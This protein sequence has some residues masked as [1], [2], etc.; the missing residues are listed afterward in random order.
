MSLIATI[1][2][3]LPTIHTRVRETGQGGAG[4]S[5]AVHP[6]PGKDHTRARRAGTFIGHLSDLRVSRSIRI[7]SHCLIAGGVSIADYDGHPLD[8]AQRRGEATLPAA[9][10][11]SVKI[12]DDVWIGQGA[13]ILKGVEIGDRAIVGAHA[14]VIRDVPA[15][16]IVAGNPARLIRQN[17]PRSIPPES[18]PAGISVANDGAILPGRADGLPAKR[19]NGHYQPAT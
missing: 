9:D 1:R 3:G 10:V 18:N 15:D 11:R 14:V 2:H 19:I 16:A 13:V 5:Y 7:G 17:P 6:G 12:G 8:A 4:V